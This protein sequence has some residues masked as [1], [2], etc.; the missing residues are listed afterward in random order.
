MAPRRQRSRHVPLALEGT[1]TSDC[2]PSE[3]V[4][5][6]FRPRTNCRRWREHRWRLIV[7]RQD[8][9]PTG[10]TCNRSFRAADRIEPTKL[11]SIERVYEL[12][13]EA[14]GANDVEA[15]AALYA[16]DT[17]LESPLVRHLLRSETG[18]VRGREKLREFIRI[19]FERTPPARRRYRSGF[20]TDGKML[21]WEY[22]RATP[23]GEQMDFV[24]VM[25]IED[26]PIHR[27][28]VYWGWFGVK[29]L[30]EDRYH[31]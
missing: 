30:Q 27:H 5:V 4:I 8:L 12:W 2:A 25:E 1:L 29:V 22:P 16:P 26:G 24:E 9:W 17:V 14:L 10:A 23:D 19:V 13:D 21:M 28:R 18:I 3:G 20:F 15:A 11:R 31:R 7:G 6:S